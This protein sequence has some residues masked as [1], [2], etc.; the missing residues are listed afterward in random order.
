MCEDKG[1]EAGTHLRL[2]TVTSAIAAFEREIEPK[3]DVSD[4]RGVFHRDAE[5]ITSF[6][7]R[8]NTK[9]HKIVDDSLNC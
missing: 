2:H 7:Q 1:G 5:R 3:P 8:A 6:I 4:S 9:T